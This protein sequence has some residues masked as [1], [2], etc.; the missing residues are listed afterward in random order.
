[1]PRQCKGLDQ[2]K[3]LLPLIRHEQ[4]PCVTDT[5]DLSG[6]QVLLSRSQPSC[7]QGCT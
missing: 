5:T 3:L 6:R 7:W 2:E 4:A 1:M